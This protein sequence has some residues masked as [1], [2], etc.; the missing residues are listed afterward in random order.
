MPG[1]ST[2]DHISAL[3]L[4][5]GK[6]HEF[7][8][9]RDLYIGFIDLRSAF[10][11]VDHNALWK[12]IKTLGTPPKLVSLFRLLYSDAESSVRVNGKDSDPFVI[13]S[14]V[15]Q[16]CVAAPALFN[17]IINHLMHQV[18]LIVPGV[19]FGSF[20]LG[21]LEYADDAALLTN[22]LKNLTL[23]LNTF[24]DE[25]AKLGLK[26]NWE[27][28]ELMFIGEGQDPAPLVY[29]GLEVKFVYKFKYL[30][31]LLTKDGNLKPEID[32]R[33]ALA[34]AAM[35]SLHR[36]LWKRTCVSRHTK[37][38][39]YQSSV[40]P[41]LL[42]GSETWALNRTL[43]ARINGFDSRSLRRI[44][45]IHWTDHV[46]N[47]ELRR[48]TGQPPASS[49]IARR[50]TRW[51]GHI[52]R[53][54]DDHP[55]KQAL[56]FDPGQAGWRRPRGAP[57]TRWLDVIARDL[58]ACGVTMEQAPQLANDRAY[59]RRLVT[60]VGFTHELQET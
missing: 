18:S 14:G 8:K 7:R 42:Y 30:G 59:W 55:T 11:T 48:R 60:L 5:I 34:A 46:S 26:V 3:R 50:R 28:T 36:P 16:G 39:I 47:E 33:R 2:V 10:D 21:D 17:C 53:M 12:I 35:K 25:A 37:M 45:R 32:R 15:R 13:N 22:T 19:Q 43:T 52:L 49:T 56:L 20:E 9:N 58:N 24:R 54:A 4:L 44:E 57:R 29:D 41:I 1:R 31:S 6:S 27:K 40:L 38:R 51:F 23:A